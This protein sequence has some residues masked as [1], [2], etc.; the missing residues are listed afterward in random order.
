MLLPALLQVQTYYLRANGH[1]VKALAGHAG[2]FAG[3]V[4]GVYT[5]SDIPRLIEAVEARVYAHVSMSS[6][7]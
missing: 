3:G 6:Y 5:C 1:P 2:E 7:V 4:P